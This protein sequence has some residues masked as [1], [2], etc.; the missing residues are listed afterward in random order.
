MLRLEFT[1]EES[2]EL[3]KLSERYDTFHNEL[4]DKITSA[5]VAWLTL[6]KGTR[7]EGNKSTELEKIIAKSQV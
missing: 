2:E 7:D 5:A 1:K 6:D 3:Q 4:Y